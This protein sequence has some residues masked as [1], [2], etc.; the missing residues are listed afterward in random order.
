MKPQSLLL[1]AVALCVA[2]ACAA[3]DLASEAAYRV[4]I[5]G[6][7]YRGQIIPGTNTPA[8]VDGSMDAPPWQGRRDILTD[9]KRDGEAV[10]S[11]FWSNMNK[12]ITVVFDLR[13]KA[14]VRTIRVWPRAG[15]KQGFDSAQARVAASEAE[16]KDATPLP[17][18]K[19]E[20]DMVWT[21]DPIEGRFVQIVCS[22]GAPQMSLAEVE[23]EGEAMQARLVADPPPGL[24]LAAPRDLSSVTR[25]PD[26]PDGVSNVAAR[27]EV[28]V[29][30]SSRHY[31][32]KTGAWGDDRFAI[33]S[34]P[35][36]RALVD[37]NHDGAVSS[38]SGWFAHK[39]I[40][41]ELDLGTPWRVERVIVWSAG[42]DKAR[43]FINSFQLWLQAGEGAAWVP[44][45][46]VRNPL[47]PGDKPGPRYPI[48]SPALDRQATRLRLKLKGV[49][50]SADVMQVSEID[51]WARAIEEPET[52]AAWRLSKPVPDIDPIKLGALSGAFD[53]V[54]RDRIRA[55]YSY[56]GRW[57]DQELLDH[58]V[59]SGFN[60]LVVHTMSTAHSE[61]GW[62]GEVRRWA[63][64]EKER[65]LHII[66]SWPFGSDERYGNTQFGAYQPGGPTQWTHTPCPLSREYWE[67]V[68]GDRALTAAQAGV[69]GMVVDMEMYGADS[70]RYRGPCYCDDCWGRFV[71]EHL[72]G[73]KPGDV[74]LADRPA[75]TA[76]NGL[77]DDYARWHQLQVSS[78]LRGIRQRVHEANPRFILGNLLGPESLP[79]L[80]RGFGTP[81]MPAL[82]FSELEYGG[83]VKGVPGHIKQL[84]DEG[85]PA[86][87]VPGLWIKPI[88]PPQL[89]ALVARVGPPSA[90]YWIWSS[91]AFSADPGTVYAHA[92]GYTHDEYW[93]AFRRSN[94]ALT[95]ALSSETAAKIPA[96]Q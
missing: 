79:G 55:L 93:E 44:A 41:A 16:L 24:I 70:T 94:Q 84:E 65:G 80:A 87:Y 40:T 5:S 17:L 4:V 1:V 67:R 30:V 50:Q 85:Y 8:V 28:T 73:V 59:A 38:F 45:Q 15:A 20:G 78:I 88:T 61:E 72:E 42:H 6:F 68:V 75:W 39:E 83:S 11:W 48:V 81:S 14:R 2:H 86:L 58:T 82:I 18:T 7:A 92:E 31:D 29:T 12:R 77:A 35:T 32:D 90:G 60:C 89:P 51:V 37:G 74:A 62:P 91:A 54:R 96:V 64:V 10:T 23:I 56:V 3:A 66:F 52:V 21:G 33:G 49:A 63:Q 22:S 9:G 53:W 47:L 36:G 57:K 95:V 46:E 25:P 13:R 27:P 26:K 69:T 34:D 43:A 19:V 76:G 71:A